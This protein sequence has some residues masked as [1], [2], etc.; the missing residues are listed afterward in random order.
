MRPVLG[1]VHASRAV[2]LQVHP[3]RN[4]PEEWLTMSYPSE[5][6]QCA[7]CGGH[8]RPAAL[9]HRYCGTCVKWHIVGRCA[10]IAQRALER[11]PK[12]RRKES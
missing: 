7:K 4:L 5:I 1:A 3:L 8:F 11:L 2:S 9:W 12:F 10:L 6:R